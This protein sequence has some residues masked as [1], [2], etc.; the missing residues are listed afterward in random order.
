MKQCKAKP[1]VHPSFLYWCD[2][3]DNECSED[4]DRPL[5]TTSLPQ[6]QGQIGCPNFQ[7][8]VQFDL[9]LKMGSFV[10]Y[11]EEDQQKK[12]V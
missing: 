1:S 10:Q 7:N 12:N 6:I 8:T 9:G 11:I 4:Y 5:L 3:S 2:L